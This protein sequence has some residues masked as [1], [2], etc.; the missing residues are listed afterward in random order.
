[1]LGTALLDGT[2]GISLLDGFRPSLDEQFVILTSAGLSGSF[3]NSTIQAGGFEFEVLYEPTQEVLKTVAIP[4]P[5]TFL[6]M[7]S[8]LALIAVARK[9]QRV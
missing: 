2:L 5:G 9:N 7:G 6:L 1:M 4:E 8:G 3:I